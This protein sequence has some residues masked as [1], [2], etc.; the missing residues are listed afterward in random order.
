MKLNLRHVDSRGRVNK[1]TLKFGILKG[2]RFDMVIGLY[3]V[4]F[5]FM[6]VIQ[7]LHNESMEAVDP[8]L[9]MLY[10]DPDTPVLSMI[11][12]SDTD[13]SQSSV[14]SN[15]N[16]SVVEAYLRNGLAM[17]HHQLHEQ[18]L[19]G[20]MYDADPI[21]ETR[22]STKHTGAQKNISVIFSKFRH[23]TGSISPAFLTFM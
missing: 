2:F 1:M 23:S 5:H 12:S 19:Y 21:Y 17:P 20:H 4:S 18:L 11:S 22:V 8:A 16:D 13:G 14:V 15:D 10:G 3:A 9:A 7:D 6:E